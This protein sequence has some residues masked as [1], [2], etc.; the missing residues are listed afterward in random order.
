MGDF[1]NLF[2]LYIIIRNAYTNKAYQYNASYN[3]VKYLATYF[4]GL[5]NQKL[6]KLFGG[7]QFSLHIRSISNTDEYIVDTITPYDV[8]VQI[9]QSQAEQGQ[10]EALVN[11]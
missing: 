4:M 10:W 9:A 11:A 3:L 6:A 2:I 8:L 7:T 5:S 1:S